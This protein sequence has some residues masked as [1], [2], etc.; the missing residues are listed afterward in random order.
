MGIWEIE[1][2]V[3]GDTANMITIA[4]A[5]GFVPTQRGDDEANFSCE[6]TD[7]NL[8]KLA[9]MLKLRI[10]REAPPHAFERVLGA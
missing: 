3:Y 6:W 10:R 4:I 9:S 2:R 7:E 5:A 1:A 8:A